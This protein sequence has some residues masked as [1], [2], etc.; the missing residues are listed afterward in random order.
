MPETTKA[1]K[2]VESLSDLFLNYV[3]ASRHAQV[4]TQKQY[5]EAWRKYLESIRDGL[6]DTPVEN[7]TKAYAEMF[8]RGLANPYAPQ[9]LQ[10]ARAFADVAQ[11]AEMSVRKALQDSHNSF[12]D[13]IQ[14][15]TM[16]GAESQKSEVENLVKAFRDGFC[17][18]DIKDL[19]AAKLG[20][21]G[22]LL[23]VAAWLRA[24]VG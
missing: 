24:Q 19:D 15:T 7:A 13:E 9:D 10:T 21:L 16:E 18:M 14:K 11:G 4:E 3:D 6:K 12:Q 1:D 17:G 22:Y 8:H 5:Y 20:R 23:L 2:T